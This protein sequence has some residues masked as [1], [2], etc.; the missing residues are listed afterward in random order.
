MASLHVLVLAAALTSNS[1][2][3]L[4]DF[5]ADWCVPC[6]SMEPVVQRLQE[7]GYPVRRI[8]IDQHPELARSFSI[9]PI[10]CF[11]LVKEGREVQRIEGATS[12]EHLVAL[13]QQAGQ[14]PLASV[15]PSY[16]GQSPDPLATGL[17]PLQTFPATSAS[18]PQPGNPPI[19]D[20]A[21]TP[22]PQS[23]P[24]AQTVQQMAL[25][26]TVRLRVTD[27]TGQSHGTG[28]IIDT[29]GDEALILTCGHLFRE[30]QG[31]GEISV[32]LF[33][34]GTRGPLAG[35][36]L[37][38][39]CD[40]RD[41]G[42]VT[43][44]PDIPVRPVRVGSPDCRPRVGDAVFTLGC[45][46]AQDPTVRASSISAI[47]RYSGP[48]N[49]EILGHPVEG[50]SGGGLFTADGTLIG[51]CNAADMQEDR[52]LFAALATIHDALARVNLQ[53][54]Y[55]AASAT[56]TVAPA[57]TTPREPATQSVPVVPASATSDGRLASDASLP[58][59]AEVI[60]V[61]RTLDDLRDSGHVVIVKNPSSE[62][63]RLLASESQ[64]ASDVRP[65]PTSP[66]QPLDM[67]RLPTAPVPPVIRAQR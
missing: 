59:G 54:I 15:D 32:E 41:Y 53:H 24:G 43:F 12:I 56:P 58:T 57:A 33:I 8:N 23:A 21:A 34:P 35:H 5:S 39:D 2:L 48:P 20:S 61:V 64:R 46:H 18:A 47:D 66:R 50:R 6:R 36:L 65:A 17:Q 25:Y 26:A 7:A 49:I 67:V 3:V 42:L 16:R 1:D 9:G 51:I 11:V 30:S 60:C 37:A 44:R 4:L 45:D 62:L 28:T 19:P 29:H 13:F 52:G 14:G 22:V 27:A 31:R 38:Y 10:P 63:L 40:K 55:L